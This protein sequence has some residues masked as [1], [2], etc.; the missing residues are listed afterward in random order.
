MAT[1]GAA[2]ANVQVT[3]GKIR[4]PAMWD[5]REGGERVR[6]DHGWGHDHHPGVRPEA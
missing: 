5:T 4:I 6:Q 1:I 3:G 2:Q